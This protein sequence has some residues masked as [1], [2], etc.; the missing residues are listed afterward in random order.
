M[1]FYQHQDRARRKTA[2]LVLYFVLAVAVIA[3]AINGVVFVAMRFNAPTPTTWQAWLATPYWRWTSVALLA[4]IG[5]GSG[6]TS[7]RLAGGGVALANMIGARR[8]SAASDDER[9]RQLRNVV[10]EMSIASGTPPP[11]LYVLD[12][13]PAINAF[14]AGTRPTATVMVVT[15]GALDT[16]TRDELQGVVAHEFSHI[17]HQDMRI[18]MRLM[19]I[20]AGILLISRIGRTMMRAGSNSREKSAWQAA[21]IGFALFVIGY[22]GVVLGSIIQAAV[23]RQRE[24]LA[25]ASAVQFTRNPLGIAGALYRI[26]QHR[27]GSRLRS[28][29]AGDLAQFCIGESVRPAFAGLL[30]THPPLAKRIAA[31]APGFV[32]RAEVAVAPDSAAPP[33]AMSAPP[34]APFVTLVPREIALSVGTVGR[35]SQASY[36]RD[37]HGALPAELRAAAAGGAPAPLVYAV[38]LAA[39]PAVARDAAMHAVTVNAGQ[40]TARSAAD[41]LSALEPLTPSARL[42]VF[43]LALPE[44]QTLDSAARVRVRDTVAAVIAADKRVSVLEFAL[45]WI[46]DD[47]LAKHAARAVA[48]RH[49]KFSA[50]ADALRTVLAVLA[51]AGSG[52]RASAEAAYRRAFTPFGLG[53]VDLPP[54]EGLSLSA[55]A[56]ALAQLAA[57]SPLLKKNV[58]GACADSVIHDGLV[59]G[60]EAALLQA[61]ALSLDCPLPPLPAA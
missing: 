20:L 39:A 33:L 57:L 23:S 61:I 36:A 16:F 8:L 60:T 52:E 55:L 59:T 29:H 54:R 28:P 11:A 25:D 3:A 44:L 24:Y 5:A 26:F 35:A 45:Q 1:N 41:L 18:N 49:F 48:V 22:L 34:R 13:E 12:D 50:V 31:I 47:H 15:R 6:Y 40:G 2:L 9:A 4:V 46:L 14:V 30:A 21:L 37:L 32:P 42:S 53:P 17:F 58:I 51:W 43:N 27:G 56:P 7:L 10:E 38:L 19:G